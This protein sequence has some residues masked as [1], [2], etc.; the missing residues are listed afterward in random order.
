MRTFTSGLE[1]MFY[2]PQVR[3]GGEERGE[4][5]EFYSLRDVYL[6]PIS[7]NNKLG[8]I[9]S[10]FYGSVLSSEKKK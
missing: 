10:F 5:F 2:L 6:K 8:Q 1:D 7:D 9:T 3:M 4:I